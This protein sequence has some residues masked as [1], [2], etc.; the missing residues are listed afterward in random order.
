MNT[1]FSNDDT[2]APG[3]QGSGQLIYLAED[4][5]DDIFLF[6]RALKA[7]KSGHSLN[8][9]ENGQQLFDA[10]Q[11]PGAKVPDI[12]FLDINMP[13]Q[14]GLECLLNIRRHHSKVLPVFLFSTAQDRLTVEQARKLGATG[15]LSKPTSTEELGALL[16]SV[17]AIDWR[18]RSV[19]DFYVH[20][21]LAST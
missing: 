17:L 6:E 21:Q 2:S 3:E 15:Y 5:H 12:V 11:K 10:L 14:T 1:A 20:L 9:F 19:N 16:T 7:L 13:V 4:D 8:T 18:S